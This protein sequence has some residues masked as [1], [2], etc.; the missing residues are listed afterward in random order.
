MT[1]VLI[2]YKV[3]PERAEEN[4]QL[5]RAVYEELRRTGKTVPLGQRLAIHQSRRPYLDN[6]RAVA[7]VIGSAASRAE[8]AIRAKPSQNL[9][10]FGK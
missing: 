4:E 7:Q 2:R 1:Q 5:V 8:S 10:T 9:V 6:R 3:K